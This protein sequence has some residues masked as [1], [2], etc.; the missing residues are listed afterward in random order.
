MR[1]TAIVCTRERDQLGRTTTI[2]MFGN[3]VGLAV[4][5]EIRD[6]LNKAIP[7]DEP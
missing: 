1:A 6:L 5:R 3:Q 4:A 2:T 7:E